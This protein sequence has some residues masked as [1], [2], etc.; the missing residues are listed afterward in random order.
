VLTRRVE[1]LERNRLRARQLHAAVYLVTLPLLITGWWLLAGREGQPSILALVLREP[2]SSIHEWFGW[3]LLVLAVVALFFGGVMTFFRE[4]L[5]YDR[6]DAR[7]LLDWPKGALV[8]HFACHQG[9]FDPGQRIA[10]A[11]IVAAGVTVIFS[12]VGLAVLPG[13]PIFI[14]LHRV[15][16]FA[17]FVLTPVLAGHVLIALG[18]LPGYRGVWRAMHLGGRVPI[19]TAHR[20]W[21]AWTERA[22]AATVIEDAK[23]GQETSSRSRAEEGTGV[24]GRIV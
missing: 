15:H 17:T 19:E 5:R 22:L 8:G 6:G 4:T 7:W 12:G 20:I 10:N 21:P 13:G 23:A 9:H 24:C 18:I 11:V 16:Q 1:T 14:W 3:S 2:D